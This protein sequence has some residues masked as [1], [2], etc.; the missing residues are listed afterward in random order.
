MPATATVRSARKR[1]SLVPIREPNGRISRASQVAIEGV[2][3]NEARRLRDAA[4]SG[5]AHEDWGSELGRL[6]LAGAID[7]ALYQAGKKWRDLVIDWQ[8]TIGAPQ[9]YPGAGPVAFLGTVRAPDTGDDPSVD[10]KEGRKLLAARRKVM[11]NMQE[12]HTVLIAAGRQA[13]A[14]VRAVCEA[15]E[16][17]AAL[18]GINNLTWG[19]AW[20]AS[21][22]GLIPD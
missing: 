16:C 4:A 8:R 17:S 6:F 14:A 20:L 15:N 1:S 22:W 12:A 11:R 5:F 2:S 10:T 7:G 13:E 19:L 18:Y 3:P 9:P 21:F